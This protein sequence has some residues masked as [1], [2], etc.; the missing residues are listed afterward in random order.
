MKNFPRVMLLRKKWNSIMKYNVIFK[1]F[2]SGK[3]LCLKLG[4]EL[5]T[6]FSEWENKQL[7]ELCNSPYYQKETEAQK[8]PHKK[9]P[10]G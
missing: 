1:P 10:E 3:E 7:T 2:L 6:S 8:Q 9:V 4:C 5:E